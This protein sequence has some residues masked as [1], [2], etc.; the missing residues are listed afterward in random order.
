VCEAVTQEVESDRTPLAQHSLSPSELKQLLAAERSGCPFLAYRDGEGG[1]VLHQL[2]GGA[3]TQTV[4]RLRELDLP[5]CWDSAV[6]AV[7]A[8]L[9]GLGGSWAIVDDG[10]SRN[11]TFVNGNR[12][13]GRR[14]LRHGDVIRVGHTLLAYGDS[15]LRPELETANVVERLSLPQLTDAQR[16]VLIA[17]CRPCLD[18]GAFATPASNNQI[19]A[20]L[21]LGVDAVKKHLRALFSKF[22]LGELPQN[23][24]RA[25]LAE[26]VMHHGL[27]SRRDLT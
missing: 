13:S 24:K 7:H 18:G 6:S 27:I 11:G 5:I 17:L 15:R 4:G 25:R 3:R 21:V 9:H 10:L 8:E 22:E 26:Y 2:D 16:R 20:E 14:R 1:L 23:Q 19:A 12:V